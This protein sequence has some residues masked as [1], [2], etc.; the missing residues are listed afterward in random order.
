MSDITSKLLATF[1]IKRTE[2]QSMKSAGR[3]P[4][5]RSYLQAAAVLHCFAPHSLQPLSIQFSDPRPRLLLFNEIVRMTGEW[6][7]QVF[8]LRLEAR[9]R[10]LRELSSREAMREALKANPNRML[11]PLQKMLEE[12]L[13]TGSTPRPEILGYNELANLC[14]MV[15]WLDGIDK[16]LPDHDFLLNLLRR[17]SILTS[18]EHLVA[19]NFTGRETELAMLRRHIGAVTESSG[20]SAVSQSIGRWLKASPKPILAIHG[21]GGIGKSAL[22]GRILWEQAQAEDLT[23]IP[24]AYLAFDQPSLRVDRPFRLLVEAAAQFELQFPEH[25]TVIKRFHENVRKYGDSRG[26]L[27]ERRKLSPSRRARIGEVRSLDQKLYSDFADLLNAIGTR[28]M[29]QKSLKSPVL[30]VLDTFEEVQYRDQ[31]S[32]VGFWRMLEII[33]EAY[34]PFRVVISGRAPVMGV[35]Q[36]NMEIKELAE[37]PMPDRVTLLER[38]GVSDRTSAEAVAAQVGGNPLSLHLAANAIASDPEAVSPY[39]IRDLITHKWLFFQIDE[40]II[41]GQLY[42]RILDHIHDE[43]VRK[44]AHPGM[45]LRRVSPEIILEVLAPLCGLSIDGLSE[46]EHLFEELKRE[47]A[48]VQVGEEGTLV[49]RPE[50][51]QAM[52]RLLEQD[53]FSEVRALRRAAINYYSKRDGLMD[54]AEEIYHRLV[55]EDEFRWLD[56]RW[57]KGIEQSVASSLEEYPDRAKAWL[58]S[59]MNLEVS[60]LVFAHANTA[61]WERNI[62]RK[63]QRALSELRLDRA[64]ELLR[65]RRERT[66]ASPL[67]ALE[68]KAHMLQNDLEN[69]AAVLARGIERVSASTNRGR[70]AELFWLQS[71]VSLLGGEPEAADHLLENAERSIEM[72][73]NPLPL[74]HVLSHRLLLRETFPAPYR[75]SSTTLR[76]RLNSVLARVNEAITFSS[77]FVVHLA[78]SL[79]GNE[80]PKTTKRFEPVVRFDSMPLG[81]PLTSENLQGL[82]EYREPWEA[83]DEPLPDE[84]A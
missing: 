26:D 66:E 8:T 34:T 38:L 57:M 46:A 6:S 51:R 44:L 81:D 70:L 14:Q 1:E 71:Q 67:F 37:L 21:A 4:R 76:T 29:G 7:E 36:T 23:A 61:D 32:M 54:R 25:S 10:A 60:R 27:G 68:A 3:D 12:Y 19:A 79:L 64:L 55:I 22:I 20:F 73:S 16:N 31:E 33:H 45:V 49:Y 13:L 82:N 11:T 63:V 9:R 77:P 15:S 47:H 52:I 59:R 28:K 41:Q 24:F 62:T 83:E 48:L 80:F 78:L 35:S 39:G 18:F 2:R 50:I 75:E 65:E 69:A 84:L 17:K 40:Q 74:M 43:N 53:K 56:D 42:R 5:L 30:L 58:A 72:S